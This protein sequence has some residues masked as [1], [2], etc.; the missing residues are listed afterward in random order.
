MNKPIQKELLA[1][2]FSFWIQRLG[3]ALAQ[4][5]SKASRQLPGLSKAMS[6]C[7]ACW[8]CLHSCRGERDWAVALRYTDQS[9]LLTVSSRKSSLSPVHS[10]APPALKE[11]MWPHP[12]PQTGKSILHMQLHTHTAP[13]KTQYPCLT[14]K[15]AKKVHYISKHKPQA[16][17]LKTV[18]NYL[19]TLKSQD[20]YRK[21]QAKSTARQVHEMLLNVL[22]FLVQKSPNYRQLHVGAEVTLLLFFTAP[23]SQ[24]LQFPARQDD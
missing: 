10:T 5:T 23:L 9:Q 24:I 2:L 19:R 18:P 4:G 21:G 15:T 6:P 17:G 8:S 1:S 16:Q 13:S 20:G 22:P 11:V 7:R 3:L 12:S 14:R